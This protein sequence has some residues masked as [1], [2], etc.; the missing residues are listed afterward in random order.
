HMEQVPIFNFSSCGQV[1]WI[2][3]VGMF[4]PDMI[5]NSGGGQ[6]VVS[7][8]LI[9]YSPPTDTIY[10]ERRASIVARGDVIIGDSMVNA[11]QSDPSITGYNTDVLH[12]RDVLHLQP[13]TS[14]PMLSENLAPS[15]TVGLLYF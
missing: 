6:P 7:P 13:R 11:S 8:E 10:P 15:D 3:S 4:I 5:P 9:P 1:E 2:Q 12:V 14:P